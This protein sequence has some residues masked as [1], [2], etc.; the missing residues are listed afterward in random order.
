MFRRCLFV[1]AV[2]VTMSA[3]HGAGRIPL[4]AVECEHASALRGPARL[5]ADNAAS[6]DQCVEVAG[7]KVEA[8][9]PVYVRRSGVY[10]VWARTAS[11][12]PVPLSL[13]VGADKTLSGTAAGGAWSW[14]KLGEARFERGRQLVRLGAD[15]AVRL[16]QLVLAGDP[17]HTPKGPADSSRGIRYALPDIDVADDFMRT[18][19][20]AGPWETALGTW[21]IS[22]LTVREQF[23]AT[24]SANAFSFRGTG[25][26]DQPA[27][28]LTGY[29]F[30][31]NY[32]IEAA[33]RSLGGAPFGLVAL[34]QDPKNYYL[35]RFDLPA[36]RVELLRCLD[37]KT[38]RLAVRQGSPLVDQWY[39]ARFAACNGLLTASVDGHELLRATDYSL[40]AGRPGLWSA[41]PKGAYFDDVLLRSLH[42][43]VADFQGAALAGWDAEGGKWTAGKGRAAGQG[44]LVHRT[45]C[46]DFEVAASITP[47]AE[48]GLVFGWR[49]ATR[50]ARLVLVPTPAR[51]E[52]REVADG[53][54]TTLASA[55]LGG[56]AKGGARR[57][58]LSQRDGRVRATVDGAASIG[59]FRP[60]AA[61]GRVGL[62]ASAPSA[63][64]ESFELTRGQQAPPT[65]VHNRIFA[66]EDTMAAWASAGSD[67]Q[68][69]EAAEANPRT[70]AWHE[71]DHTGDC[72][73][74]YT[75]PVLDGAAGKL[76]LVVRGDGA[77][78]DSGYQLIVQS[79]AKGPTTLTLVGG[80]K[81]LGT[82]KRPQGKAQAVELSWLANSV[83]A[84]VDGEIVLHHRAA[85]PPAGRRIG[86][87]AEG[88]EPSLGHVR[89]ESANLWNDYF[90]TAPCAWRADTGHW[91]MQHRW[92]CSPQWSWL[93][94]GS[95]DAALLWSK[96]AF[97]GDVTVHFFAAFAMRKVGS[98]IYRPHDLNVS[99]CADGKNPA[100]GYTLLYGG[101]NNAA[102]SLLRGEKAVATTTKV[103]LRPPTMLDT[104]PST[105]YLHRKWWHVAIEKKGNVVSCYVDD[106][107]ACRYT[108]PKPLDG[109]RVCLWTRN[110]TVMI[111]RTWITYERGG[112]FEHP[113]V[114]APPM[115]AQQAAPPATRS[116]HP[117]ILEDFEGGL[118]KWAG[119]PRQSAVHLEARGKGRALAVVNPVSGGPFTLA[120]PVEP[121]DAMALPRLSFDYRLPASVRV[122]LRVTLG[123]AVH[124][125]TLTDPKTNPVGIMPIGSAGIQADDAWHTAH[126]DLRALLLRVRPGAT[127][128]P[129]KALAI[130][131]PTEPDSY[132]CA[133]FGG[134]RAG[135]TYRLDNVRLWG[136]GPPDVGFA[137]DATLIARHTLDR[138]PDTEPAGVPTGPGK[139]LAKGL[140]DGAWFFHLK[141]KPQKGAWGRAAHHPFVV[142]TKPPRVAASSPK[143][144]AKSPA[145]VVTVDFAD[146]AGV[147]P[148]SLTAV[149]V[150]GKSHPVGILPALPSPPSAAQPATFD[151]V[152]GRLTV[153]LSRLPL[154]LKDGQ[155]LELGL[156]A[157]ADFLGHKMAP[158]TLA[159]TFDAK[160]DKQP[161]SALELSSSHAYLCRDGFEAGL[162]QWQA[163]SSEG[164]A[165]SVIERDPTTA[166]SGRYSLRILNPHAG[167]SFT[168]VVRSEPFDAGQYPLVA[169]DYKIP[170]NL[171]TDLLL[172]LNGS[173]Y[174]V[175]FTD[176]NGSHCIGAIPGV[177]AD[178]Q[179]HHTE[180]NLHEILTAAVP[181]A[182]TYTV[183]RL[184][185]G[186]TG[187]F[188]NNDGVAYHIDNFTIAPA[189]STRLKPLEWKL[190]ATDPSGI[191][192][193]QYSI[194]PL[195][196]P[197]KWRDATSPTWTFRNL[198]AGIFHFHVRARDGAGNWSRPISRKILVD[199]QPPAVAAVYPKPGARAADCT[200][201]LTLN[202]APAGL[203]R[204]KT[205][206]L[207]GGVAYSTAQNGVLY[208]ARS[209]TLTWV[210]H[211]LSKPVTFPNGANVQCE[212]RAED[213][214][215]NAATHKWTW[216]MDYALDK[217]PPPAPY[218]ARVPDKPLVRDTF[219]TS[220]GRWQ[221]YSKYGACTRTAATAATGRYAVRMTATRSSSYFGAY[222]RR[223]VYNAA[224]Y[225]IISF[226]YNIPPGLPINLHVYMGSWRTIR[227]TSPSGYYNVV[228]H[229]P[230]KADSQWHHA[231]ID[232][233]KF[234]K[235]TTASKRPSLPVTY[236]RFGDF[237]TRSVS[238]GAYCHFD[239]FSIATPERGRT[240]TF[241]WT[242]VADP[243]GI[244]GYAYALD[245][246]PTTQPTKLLGT[247]T[248]ATFKDVAPGTWY[249]HLRARDGVGHWSKAV[250]F[251]TTVTP[252]PPPPPVPKS[253]ATPR[254]KPGR[255]PRA[256][257]RVPKAM[258]KAL[259]KPK[260]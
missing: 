92:T 148:R 56:S 253:S 181:K 169:F 129:V 157:V 134:N 105:N 1:S 177:V 244:A 141:G 114:A 248:T 194:G 32:S 83:A 3:G 212:L 135:T 77:K 62:F 179:W 107:L 218:V 13:A 205:R 67:W 232:L 204:E 224:V 210:G 57:V 45:E 178:N 126:L 81:T 117:G 60:A 89:V 221:G 247:A 78:P 211:H 215:G 153:H 74:R 139:F 180:L 35:L 191:A 233:L 209:H 172:T 98:R 39:R 234:L 238:A 122:N 202:D 198:G 63:S 86:L 7:A 58:R 95:T 48:S 132:L 68:L 185:F 131:A 10:H 15:G 154:S 227:L 220:V 30:W 158:R 61:R 184:A 140:S 241:E 165:Y 130:A 65:V 147:D 109:G 116:T 64:F 251:P 195:P 16:D 52:L 119:T 17:G 136:A 75:L 108:D 120:F 20:E 255:K 96:R 82:A 40:L 216:K 217:A 223:R 36:G 25:A 44:V 115:P 127:S 160:G 97:R 8:R 143:A 11:P 80:G 245:Q 91:E 190:A 50:H 54:S 22:E 246:K 236:V 79:P 242:R 250:H 200:V 239:N 214:V 231:E 69:T 93:G 240:L 87:W 71:I 228:G 170:T 26:K 138:K 252:G 146:D 24:R 6:L 161:P 104:T 167:G 41:D 225:P 182:P 249:L 4:V 128:L 12:K 173:N 208:D 9:V 222:A 226:D 37:G 110:N 125:V 124:A 260:G 106:Q 258:R 174:T 43:V 243:T 29:P 206:L 207:I 47:A 142:D 99:I 229:V 199:D 137:W 112:E 5:R 66:G 256:K 33:V 19:R 192:A 196:A 14:V 187:F 100:S 156:P 155:T 145:H 42:T 18:N 171:R 38:T 53:K 2:L 94:G 150:N 113:L 237:A 55:P 73:V 175:R 111:A 189:A 168:V 193:Y 59:A 85:K 219:E 149:T 84:F 123:S 51:V 186:D 121:F 27:F 144:G 259:A 235:P 201:R 31:R 162:G 49:S 133:G 90:E 101:W 257:P 72:S 188:G 183:S 197:V 103:S 70:V 163:Y 21:A 46:D 34:H 213:N 203:N 28:A 76:G 152:G 254:P 118:G 88:W 151:P 230:L 166:A 164:V 102:T 23:D 159:W 176:P